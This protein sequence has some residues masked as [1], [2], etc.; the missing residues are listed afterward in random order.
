MPINS[1]VVY[2]NRV[3]LDKSSADIDL[4]FND[5]LLE[6][7]PQSRDGFAY[8]WSSTKAS[9]GIYKETK[10]YFEVKI[11]EFMPVNVSNRVQSKPEITVGW[12]VASSKK[13][14]DSLK[15]IGFNSVGRIFHNKTSKKYGTSL[16]VNDILG[17]YIVILF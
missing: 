2:S 17:C 14:G 3:T 11:L 4:M 12:S 15:S 5:D 6:V 16:V 9:H 8:M 10:A 7:Y 13:I 1:S